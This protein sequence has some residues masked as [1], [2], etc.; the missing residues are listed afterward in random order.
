M[1]LTLPFNDEPVEQ[2][3]GNRERSVMVALTH[4]S[5]YIY[6]ANV[7]ESPELHINI[8]FSPSSCCIH[9]E[10]TKKKSKKKGSS[11]NCFGNITENQLLSL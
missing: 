2:I 7:S 5:L 8:S 10:E 6:L 1:E 3:V 9:S 4:S 11:R